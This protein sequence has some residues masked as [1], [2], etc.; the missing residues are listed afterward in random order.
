MSIPGCPHGPVYLIPQPCAE[1]A[2]DRD[3][4]AAREAAIREQ[5]DALERKAAAIE[6]GDTNAR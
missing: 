3:V 2:R 6:Q 4:Q 1:C 5:L